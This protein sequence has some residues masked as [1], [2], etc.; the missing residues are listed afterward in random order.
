VSRIYQPSLSR[1]AGASD[2]ARGGTS[3]VEIFDPSAPGVQCFGGPIAHLGYF[4]AEFVE[5]RRWLRSVSLLICGTLPIPCRLDVGGGAIATVAIFLPGLLVLMG[6]T[7]LA[8]IA[9]QAQG[10]SCDGRHQRG[11]L[12]AALYNPYGP[13]RPSGQRISL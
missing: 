1:L 12:G 13:A 7:L 6:T 9:R 3:P 8:G 5:R 10:T 4:S 2:P 11:L